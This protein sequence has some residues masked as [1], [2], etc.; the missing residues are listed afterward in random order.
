MASNLPATVAEAEMAPPLPKKNSANSKDTHVGLERPVIVK[1]TLKSRSDSNLIEIL[2]KP[3]L[4]MVKS[5]SD[6]QLITTCTTDKTPQLKP[7]LDDDDDDGAVSDETSSVSVH[8][9]ENMAALNVNRTDWGIR[10]WKS[11]SDIE[12]SFHDN[13]VCKVCLLS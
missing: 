1:G 13:S 9:Y 2:I 4:V 5:K 10:H 8:D 6:G 12:N 7:G 3:T 11:Y